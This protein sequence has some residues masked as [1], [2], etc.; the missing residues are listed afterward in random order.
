MS[1]IVRKKISELNPHPYNEEIYGA[2]E[3]I[4]ELVASIRKTGKVATLTITDNDVIISGHRRWK[5]CKQ[6]V[7]IG[8]A[9]V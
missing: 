8:R 9:H 6:L 3:S 2:N 1:T 7:K 4:D 5:S